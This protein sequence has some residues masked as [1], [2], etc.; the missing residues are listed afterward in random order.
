MEVIRIPHEAYV[1]L[2]VLWPVLVLVTGGAVLARVVAWL[3][4]EMGRR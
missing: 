2:Y 1:L 3:L 4:S